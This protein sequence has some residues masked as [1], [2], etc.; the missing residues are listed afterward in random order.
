MF[1]RNR[2]P[3]FMFEADGGSG[4]AGESKVDDVTKTDDTQAGQ[5]EMI[6]KEEALKLV[7]SEADKVRGEYSKK[8]KDR[9]KELED[10]RLSSMTDSERKTEELKIR[11]AKIAEAEMKLQLATLTNQTTDLLVEAKL[12]LEAKDFMIGK[13]IESTKANIEAFKKMFSSALESA[14][15]ERFK[16]TGKE[17]VESGKTTRYTQEDLKSMT[18]AEINAN[19]DKIQRDLSGK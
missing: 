5:P 17:H 6:T 9:E 11:E 8:L 1:I 3:L 14:V 18:P 7:Q 12:P 16:Q 19:W 13:D 4:G 15:T 10:T 2:L